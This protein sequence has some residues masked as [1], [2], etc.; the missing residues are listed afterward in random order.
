MK[1]ALN[2]DC[3]YF[4]NFFK[5]GKVYDPVVDRIL[6]WLRELNEAGV[7]LLGV[8]LTEGVENCPKG[9][10]VLFGVGSIGLNLSSNLSLSRRL[11]LTE[12]DS[13]SIT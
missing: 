7:L 8:D 13:A 6:Y 10:L 11:L 9:F 12:G 3:Y 4:L 1:L 2:E 5:L